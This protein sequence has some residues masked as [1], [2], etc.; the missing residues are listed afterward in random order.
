MLLRKS[1]E[2]LHAAMAILVSFEQF[3]RK[4]CHIFGP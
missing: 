3:L 4:F 1:L 2:N